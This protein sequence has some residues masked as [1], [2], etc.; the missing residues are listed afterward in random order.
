MSCMHLTS[1]LVNLAISTVSNHFNQ[2]KYPRR[3]LKQYN[4]WNS[5]TLTK[6]HTFKHQHRHEWLE[7][8]PI[9]SLFWL[10]EMHD[11]RKWWQNI[12][13]WTVSNQVNS[14]L[15]PWF[16]RCVVQ[17]K[18]RLVWI[19]SEWTH[20]RKLVRSMSSKLTFTD[21]VVAILDSQS[22][23]EHSFLPVSSGISLRIRLHAPES[24]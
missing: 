10:G 6:F 16:V 18:Y 13:V 21:D 5:S 17:N 19:K 20:T 23:W 8:I 24:S 1:Y 15:T 22:A 9:Y 11:V 12:S 3:F 14:Y 4:W 2:I 7:P